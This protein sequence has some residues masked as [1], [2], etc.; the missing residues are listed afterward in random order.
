MFPCQLLSLSP[1]PP[2]SDLQNLLS[3]PTLSSGPLSRASGLGK[4]PDL[5]QGCSHL[6][7]VFR[8]FSPL[9]SNQI[10]SSSVFFPA[11]TALRLP[12]SAESK[13]HSFRNCPFSEHL[14]YVSH[15]VISDSLRPHGLSMGFSRQGYWSGL[16]FHAPEDLP[17]P[18]IKLRSPGLQTN[19]LPSEPPGKP[20]LTR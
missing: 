4:M 2:S 19:S 7:S 11:H 18:E 14:V 3:L 5:R 15:S 12:I 1:F 20:L 6:D 10:I 16:P 8:H 9:G 13:H 17:D